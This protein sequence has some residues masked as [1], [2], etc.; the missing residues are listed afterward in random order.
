MFYIELEGSSNVSFDNNNPSF[1]SSLIYGGASERV[2]CGRAVEQIRVGRLHKFALKRASEEAKA[3]LR[4]AQ[5]EEKTYRRPEER[6]SKDMGVCPADYRCVQELFDSQ[7]GYH[8]NHEELMDEA[9]W[10]KIA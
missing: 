2:C 9:G 7:G 5:E 10:M 4:K 6:S 1:Q 3:K 8:F